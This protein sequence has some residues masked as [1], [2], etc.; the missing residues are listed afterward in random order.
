VPKTPTLIELPSLSQA[1][2]VKHSHKDFYNN[3]NNAN[4]EEINDM[5]ESLI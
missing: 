4:D 1:E 5:G 2:E 3:T